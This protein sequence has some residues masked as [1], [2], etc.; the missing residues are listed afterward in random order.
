ME[1]AGPEQGK[2]G[3]QKNIK[4]AENKDILIEMICIHKVP[5]ISTVHQFGDLDRM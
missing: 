5:Q 4:K 2:T 1:R 3:T